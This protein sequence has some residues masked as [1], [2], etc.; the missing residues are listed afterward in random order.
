ME[1]NLT[2]GTMKR[3]SCLKE[4]FRKIYNSY[5]DNDQGYQR[6]VDV[7]TTS[8]LIGSVGGSLGIFFGFSF[9]GYAL[10]LHEKCVSIFMTK[11]PQSDKK[12]ML[13]LGV[14][15]LKQSIPFCARAL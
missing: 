11:L 10:Y 3:S 6:E 2:L 9:S 15:F 1:I 14:M 7:I 12:W 4:R 8:E 5:P 13:F